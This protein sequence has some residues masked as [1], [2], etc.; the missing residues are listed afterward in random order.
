[1]GSHVEKY[2]ISSII[3]TIYMDNLQMVQRFKNEIQYKYQKNSWVNSLELWKVE[4]LTTSQNSGEERREK[5]G[6]KI[7]P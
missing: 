2:Y 5:R 4:G 1:M 7:T 6:L 3:N